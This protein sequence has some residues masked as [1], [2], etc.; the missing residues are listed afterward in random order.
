V[1]LDAEDH[2]FLK[3]WFEQSANALER[4]ADVLETSRGRPFPETTPTAAAPAVFLCFHCGK[5]SA[6]PPDLTRGFACASCGAV[7]PAV[8][9]RAPVE[10]AE[11][12]VCECSIPYFAA[13]DGVQRCQQ[14]GGRP[15]GEQPR[16]KRA[17]AESGIDTER[18]PWAC[19]KCGGGSLYYTAGAPEPTCMRCR[20]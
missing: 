2:R 14:C 11:A 4:I 12:F 5:A 9:E 19:P 18:A 17:R 10:T 16:N 15:V 3:A 7:Y 1:S 13:I 20:Q 6:L 8:L